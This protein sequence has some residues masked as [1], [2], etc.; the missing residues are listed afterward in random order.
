MQ[1]KA[2]PLTLQRTK[3]PK[4]GIYSAPYF[5]AHVKKV[6]QQQ[7][8]PA[9]VFKGGLTVYTTLDTRL[10][11]YAEKRRRRRRSTTP[12][13]PRSPSSPST[14]KNGYVKALV[15]GRDYNKRK[16]NLATQGYRQ[17]GSSF[18]TFVLAEAIDQGMPPMVQ[19]RLVV[20]SRDSRQAQALDRRQQRGRGTRHDVARERDPRSVN[21]VFARVAIRDRHQERREDGQADGHRDEA[22]ELS[23]DRAG[24]QRT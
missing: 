6:L 22:A 16:F 20:A 3:E 14:R 10:Q 5:V 2:E 13:T 12:R 18:K 8:T 23:L 17:P 15:G 7:F 9:V 24:R 21:T 11:G 4:D 1:A 19:G